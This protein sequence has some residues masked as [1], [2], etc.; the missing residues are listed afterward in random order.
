ML[1]DLADCSVVI[2][3]WMPCSSEELPQL[4]PPIST[5]TSARATS[6]CL[7]RLKLSILTAEMSMGAGSGLEAANGPEQRSRLSL[8]SDATDSLGHFTFC[9]HPGRILCA[10]PPRRH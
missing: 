3:K 8:S 6:T 9:N 7:I 10:H 4:L 5:V 1:A 2:A